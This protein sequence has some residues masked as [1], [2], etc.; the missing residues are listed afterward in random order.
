MVAEDSLD[1]K[2]EDLKD[3]LWSNQK[4]FQA[5]IDDDKNGFVDDVYG[6]NFLGDVY[7]ENLETTKC[8]SIE[9]TLKGKYG[10]KG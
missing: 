5:T 6:W 7:D 8:K 9:K 1:I 10:Y 3:V 2:H 4:K